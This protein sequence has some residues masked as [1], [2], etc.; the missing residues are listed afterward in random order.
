MRK[1]AAA[2]PSSAP[3][4]PQ[5]GARDHARARAVDPELLRDPR[6]RSRVIP[7]DHDHPDPG[8]PG[9]V[10]R[11]PSLGPGRID[12]PH[13]PEVDQIV[14]ERGVDLGELVRR[15][16]PVGDREGAEG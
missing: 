1:C 11:R 7:G 14:L 8:T 13:D 12:D 16:R 5:I 6:R 3:N 4:E 10:N 15:Q 9:L 2:P